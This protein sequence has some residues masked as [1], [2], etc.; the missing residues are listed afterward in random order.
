MEELNSEETLSDNR[1]SLWL[2]GGTKFAAT[3]MTMMKAAPD[4]LSKELD[5]IG[6]TQNAMTYPAAC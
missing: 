2:T 4:L 6:L 5:G 3:R 1:F